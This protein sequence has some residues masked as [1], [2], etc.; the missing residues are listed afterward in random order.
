MHAS[1]VTPS[2]RNSEWLKLCIASVADQG[3]KAEHIVQDAGSDDGTQ[4][5]LPHDTRVRAFIEKDKGMYDAVNR[6]LKRAEG[7]ILAYLNCDEQY[8]PGALS[9]VINFFER[10]PRVDVVFGD[11]VVVNGDGDYSFHRKVQTPLKYHTWVSH[12]S[13]FTCATFFR[14]RLIDEGF[15]FDPNFRDVGDGEWMLRLLKR[16]TRMAVMRQFTSAFTMTGVN[17]STRPNARREAAELFNSAP[18]WARKMRPMLI[19]QHRLRRLL[20]GIYQQKPFSYA[21]YSQASPQQRL[22]HKVD[23]PKFKWT[24]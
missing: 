11:F 21:I 6:G 12:L 17:M 19:W 20:G 9:G 14:R 2:F 22:V 4:D 18:L 8:L 5:W 10:H 3:V 23:Q 16:G 24:A 13:T 15:L 7:D 1:I